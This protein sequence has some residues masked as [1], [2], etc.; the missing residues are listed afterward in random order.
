MS[1]VPADR[2][3]LQKR[4]RAVDVPDSEICPFDVTCEAPSA[5]PLTLA[6]WAIA[7]TVCSLAGL[8]AHHRDPDA[9]SARR[10]R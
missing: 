10:R 5:P 4:K 7:I 9:A 2:K 1:L 8:P 6:G 3:L